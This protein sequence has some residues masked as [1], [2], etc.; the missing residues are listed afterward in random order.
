MIRVRT[1]D[2]L[3]GTEIKKQRLDST[4]V[5]SDMARFGRL[6]LLA[7]TVKRF[8]VQ[9]K[10]HHREGYDALPSDL[11]GRYAAAESRR[12][13]SGTKRP[14]P[15]EESLRQVAEDI[16]EIIARFARAVER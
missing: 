1:S 12:F 15:Y 2:R 14:Q 4:H 10:R 6:R 3:L 9:L 7:A 5:L 8:L 11:R 16:G 13:G